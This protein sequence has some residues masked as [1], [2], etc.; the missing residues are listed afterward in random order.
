MRH[1]HKEAYGAAV[2]FIVFCF[3]VCFPKTAVA[4]CPIQIEDPSFETPVLPMTFLRERFSFLGASTQYCP[5]NASHIA[6]SF[7]IDSTLSCESYRIARHEGSY[8]RDNDHHDD[9]G[10]Q[11]TVYASI[12]LCQ[13]ENPNLRKGSVETTVL[14]FLYGAY[15]TLRETGFAFLHPFDTLVPAALGINADGSISPLMTPGGSVFVSFSHP[16]RS[17]H[18]H[19]MHPLEYTPYFNGFGINNSSLLVTEDDGSFEKVAFA[20]FPLICEWMIVIQA[21]RFSWVLLEDDSFKLFA[22]SP[23]RI[24]RLAKLVDI[25]HSFGLLVG[26]DVPVFFQQQHSWRLVPG[27]YKSTADAVSQMK[28]RVDYLRQADWDFLETEMGS[29]EFTQTSDVEMVALLNATQIYIAD[30]PTVRPISLWVKVHCSQGQTAPHYGNI[31]YNFVAQFA[32][33]RVVLLPHTV[34]PFSLDDPT[35]NSY[36]NRNFTFML[37]F[38]KSLPAERRSVYYGETAYWVNDDTATGMFWPIYID[39][40]AHDLTIIEQE[41]PYCQGFHTFH[42][43]FAWGYNLIDYAL[44]SLFDTSIRPRLSTATAERNWVKVVSPIFGNTRTQLLTDLIDTQRE[45]F[46]ENDGMAYV[47]GQDTWSEIGDDIAHTHEQPPRSLTPLPLLM[48][49]KF[50]EVDKKPRDLYIQSVRSLLTNMRSAFTNVTDHMKALEM[51]DVSQKLSS[52]PGVSVDWTSQWKLAALVSKDYS[53]FWSDV[54]DGTSLLSLRSSQI[55]LMY[56]SCFTLEFPTDALHSIFVEATSIVE[57]GRDRMRVAYPQRLYGWIPSNPTSYN[58][59]YLWT[60]D[61]LY[62]MWRDVLRIHESLVVHA[63]GSDVIAWLWIWSPCFL[64]MVDP[65]QIAGLGEGGFSTAFSEIVSWA[66]KE[67]QRWHGH[68]AEP[69]L[70]CTSAPEQAFPVADWSIFK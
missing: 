43:G 65:L 20:E 53:S 64:N 30:E 48:S 40:R 54:L 70:R 12:E 36:G 52:T 56:E 25:A 31:D 61:S 13:S 11:V 41:V 16:V 55:A 28:A 1:V 21:N 2:A 45:W 22:Q 66:I 14:A 27:S 50:A 17:Y 59:M 49:S 46:I 19:S 7:A 23:E 62:F 47:Q 5:S 3:C 9:S 33:P 8:H 57:R 4:T 58:H 24:A 63:G 68:G 29:S 42:S 67:E 44:M 69:F 37:D 6:L 39:R 35:W 26:L 34:Q 10:F 18:L 32:D 15:R 38:M 51:P 60:A